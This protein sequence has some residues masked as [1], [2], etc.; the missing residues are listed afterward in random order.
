MESVNVGLSIKK[1]LIGRSI[2]NM[3]K[4]VP[5]IENSVQNLNILL[6]KYL[7]NTKLCNDFSL[8]LKESLGN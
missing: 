2:D 4:K 1:Y 3:K 8:Q 6:K 7:E 5:N